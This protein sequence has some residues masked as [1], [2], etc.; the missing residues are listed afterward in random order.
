MISGFVGRSAL[1]A[2]IQPC[3][4]MKAATD[5]KQKVGMAVFQENSPAKT[6]IGL[7]LANPRVTAMLQGVL[8]STKMAEPSFFGAEMLSI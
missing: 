3:C 6:C 4:S 5:S 7:G 8:E 2:T 1:T